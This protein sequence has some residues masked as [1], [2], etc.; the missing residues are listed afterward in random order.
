MGIKEE[1]TAFYSKVGVKPGFLKLAAKCANH[2][3]FIHVFCT[4]IL[5]S[6]EF[7]SSVY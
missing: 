1:E 6:F 5:L 7:G 2:T 4:S 3:I